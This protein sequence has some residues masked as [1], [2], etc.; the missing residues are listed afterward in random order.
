MVVLKDTLEAMSFVNLVSW[1]HLCGSELM[2][3]PGTWRSVSFPG[4]PAG[5]YLNQASDFVCRRISL[6]VVIVPR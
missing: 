3:D 4:S 6:Q 5:F 2:R 1:L